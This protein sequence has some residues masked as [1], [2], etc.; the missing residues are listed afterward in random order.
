MG[1]PMDLNFQLFETATL[2]MTVIVVAFM[3]Q[4]I[5]SNGSWTTDLLSSSSIFCTGN[6]G[7]CRGQSPELS[8]LMGS[9][10]GIAKAQGPFITSE[11]FPNFQDGVV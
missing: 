3:L 2:F 1:R 4:K 11:A 7:F 10:G 9:K 8:E 6:V 5:T